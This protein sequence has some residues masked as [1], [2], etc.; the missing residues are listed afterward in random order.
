MTATVLILFGIERCTCRL[1]SRS[2]SSLALSFGRSWREESPC[3]GARNPIFTFPRS[4]A[5]VE[6]ART[7]RVTHRGR[8]KETKCDIVG[9]SVCGRIVHLSKGGE[10]FVARSWTVYWE[11]PDLAQPDHIGIVIAS[12][13]TAGLSAC[14]LKPMMRGQGFRGSQIRP[15]AQT[16]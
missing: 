6:R 15:Q 7:V 9:N 12:Q 13:R 16:N 4:W 1:G 10:W 8:H 3:R 11:C 14:L 5:H 2:E